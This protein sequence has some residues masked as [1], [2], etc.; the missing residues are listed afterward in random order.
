MPLVPEASRGRRGVVQ[1]HIAAR[2]HLAGHVHVVVFDEHQVALQ[3]A[4][5]AQVNDVL[6]VAFA[7]IIPR[8]RFAGEMN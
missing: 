6:D 2:N 1:P 4:V 5:L 3:V 8:M 7:F